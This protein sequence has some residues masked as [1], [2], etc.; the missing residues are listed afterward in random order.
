[1]KKK[2][3]ILLLHG[4]KNPSWMEPFLELK[5]KVKAHSPNAQIALAC[6]Q[7]GSPTLDETIR[8]LFTEGIK[9]FVIVPIFISARGHV[10]K[11]VPLLV[12]KVRKLHPGTEISISQAVGELPAVQKAII[13]G[14]ISI[15]AE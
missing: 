7:F 4:S 15:A 11:D 10:T 5:T 1:V 3:I 6:L 9:K 12:D 2:A 8:A 13:D 14:I